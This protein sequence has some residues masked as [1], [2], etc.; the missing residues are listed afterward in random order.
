V[1]FSFPYDA[2]VKVTKHQQ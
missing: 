2:I 1:S